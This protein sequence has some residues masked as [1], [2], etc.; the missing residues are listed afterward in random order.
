LYTGW[1]DGVLRQW[2]AQHRCLSTSPELH[3]QRITKLCI[4]PDGSRI[5]T[6]GVDGMTRVW[7][8]ASYELLFELRRDSDD[9]GVL[10][11]SHDGRFLA[12]TENATTVS[13]VDP[14]TWQ[15]ARRIPHDSIVGNALFTPDSRHLV[16]VGQALQVWDVLT[17]RRVFSLPVACNELALSQDG[18]LLASSGGPRITVVDL[19]TGKVV[20]NL[21]TIGSNY[22][23]LAIHGDTL[24]AAVHPPACITLWDLRTGQELMRLDT[25]ERKQHSIAFSP[26]GTRLIATGVD[27]DGRGRI[28]DWSIDRHRSASNGQ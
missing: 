6:F 3:R 28:W 20:F 2:D 16:T 27:A 26:D 1:S 11:W 8:A 17:G 7:H 22:P 13:L 12:A 21:A 4:A 5:A 24:A 25:V 23:D 19:A 18:R 9:N 14:S 15:V 10:A